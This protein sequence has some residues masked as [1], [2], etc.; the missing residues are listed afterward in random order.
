MKK[1]IIYIA[2]LV[3]NALGI[4]AQVTP[5]V[6]D[7]A[8]STVTF[9][10]KNAGIGVDGSFKEYAAIIQF[11]PKNLGA[12]HFEG[13]IKTKSIHTGINGRDNHL[14]KEEFFYVDKYPEIHFRSTAIKPQGNTYVVSGKLTIKDVTK[15]VSWTLKQ[16]KNGTLN[17]YET[18]LTINR[19]DYHVG[20]DSW[21]MSDEVL[22]NIIITTK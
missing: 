17:V 21:T 8:S 19:L 18:S 15:D 2:V 10:I 6:L 5:Q 14:R 4:F 12:S 22:I 1:I 16:S 13:K 9:K 20:E 7:Y 3:F 11:D